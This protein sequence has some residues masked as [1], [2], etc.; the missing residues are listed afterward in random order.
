MQE[1]HS[2]QD[3]LAPAELTTE[4]NSVVDGEQH[5]QDKDTAVDGE[6]HHQ[7]KDTA[8]DGEQHHQD[9]DTAT[10]AQAQGGQTENKDTNNGFAAEEAAEARSREKNGESLNGAEAVNAARAANSQSAEIAWSVPTELPDLRNVRS[11]IALDSETKDDRLKVGLGSGWPVRQ[12]YICGVSIAWR[13]ENGAIQARYFPIRHP[14]TEGF[15]PERIYE[16]I[17]DHIAVGVK[18]VTQHGLYDWGWLRSEAGIITP[19]GNQIEEI[20]ALAT[21]IDEYTLDNLC[22]WRGLPGKDESLLLEGIKALGLITDKHKKKIVPQ[23]YI[24]AL[25]ARY[26]GPY[27]ET[28]AIRTLQLFED[29][30]PIIDQ[31][32]TRDAYRLECDL[33]PMIQEMQLRGIRVDLDADECDRDLIYSARLFCLRTVKRWKRWCE[34]IRPHNSWRCELA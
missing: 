13:D 3:E 11:P 31:Q 6:Q 4:A 1:D 5:H 26:V 7:D 8:V 14:D 24:W 22:K 23:E 32:G 18:F 9:K 25:P 12:G 16:W 21:L 15:A 27:A 2:S 29:L 10:G 28:D 19:E 20:G 34:P 17:R 30:N 33:M